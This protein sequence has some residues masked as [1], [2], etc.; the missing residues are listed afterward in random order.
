MCVDMGLI[1]AEVRDDCPSWL[2]RICGVGFAPPVELHSGFPGLL[3]KVMP[4][5]AFVIFLFR[6]SRSARRQLSVIFLSRLRIT[7]W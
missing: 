3:V 1:F 7:V 4:S 2:L 5:T 6:H